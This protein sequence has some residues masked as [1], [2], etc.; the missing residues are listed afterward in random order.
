VLDPTG[1]PLAGIALALSSSPSRVRARSGAGGGFDVAVDEPATA[2]LSSDPKFA[3]VL[4]GS[5]EV[6][7]PTRAIVVVAPSLDIGGVVIDA[8]R[9]PLAD[10]AVEFSLPP[11]F[12]SEWG[13]PLDYTVRRTW[14]T[15]SGPDGRF[16][17][18]S[19]PGV[20]GARISAS[21]AGYAPR[22][23]PAPPASSAALEI[24]LA[25]PEAVD[26]LVRGVVLDPS[27]ARAQGARV[28]AG[29]EIALTDERGEF[30]L[31]VR[32]E[33]TRERIVALLPGLLP[34]TFE[35][36]RDPGGR[37]LWPSDV[38]LQLGG[39]APTI[40][41]R[42]VDAEGAPIGGAKV[43]LKDPTSF[44]SSAE[45]R[46]TAEGLLRGDD[47][48]WSF[49]TT[50][51]DGSFS[52]AGVLA[53]PYRLEAVDPRTLAGAVSE[54]VAPGDPL[55]E[56]RLPTRDVHEKVAGRVV[57][58]AGAPIPRVGV[59]LVR[60]TFEL[61]H[62]NGTDNESEQGES[63]VTGDD[64]A[65]EFRNV[66]RKGIL[67][68]ATGDTILGAGGQLEDYPDPTRLELVASLRLHLQVEVAAPR[69]RADRLQVLDAGGALVLLS[70]FH[71][72]GAHASHEMPIR[73]G[74]S[75]V[76]AVEERAATL[77]L[78]RGD[79]EVARLP[80]DLVPGPTNVVRY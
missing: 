73:D 60:I 9:A 61:Q 71:G 17:L 30:R 74:R 24:V 36:E 66:P 37:L 38:V 49:V 50:E 7:E 64:G 68:I 31:D 77:V 28:S 29:A 54:P 21:L 63:V 6:R 2:I 75:D 76:L 79:E 26:G 80:L 13:I 20:A 53:R 27:G 1:S 57:T 5:A 42:V 19:V 12:G 14:R 65:F 43:W 70:V 51:A 52:L 8:T 10:A 58:H 15:K 33:G 18:A 41:G 72:S 67:V 69:N 25:H 40:R 78:Y 35:P 3:T 34:A 48:F 59:R 11:G 44:G 23:E 32:I 4:G 46:L 55:V 22:A 62:E 16:E 45:A 56:L 47:R 39:K